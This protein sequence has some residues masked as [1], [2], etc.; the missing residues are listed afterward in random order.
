MHLLVPHAEANGLQVRSGVAG[1]DPVGKLR[2][3]Q[4]QGRLLG[5]VWLFFN[6]MGGVKESRW[7][8]EAELPCAWRNGA[9]GS[10]VRFCGGTPTSLQDVGH[11]ATCCLHQLWYSPLKAQPSNR[12]C[13]M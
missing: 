5:A 9:P 13:P 4:A 2:A 11:P 7:K 10:E 12:C 1:H 6:Y 3:R 8:S